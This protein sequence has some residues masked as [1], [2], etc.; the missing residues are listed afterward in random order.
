MRRLALFFFLILSF[1]RAISQDSV[2]LAHT[3]DP[4]AALEYG[5]GVDRLG[6]AKMSFLDSGVTLTVVDSFRDE[7]KIRLSQL[8]TAYIG[9]DH[10][11]LTRKVA[12]RETG[13]N[14]HLSGDWKIYGDDR[15]DFVEIAL[16]SR[17]PYHS[18]QQINPSRIIVE[19]YG[20]TSNTNWINQ[21]RSAREIRACWYEQTEDDLLRVIVELRHPTFWGHSLYY[22]S[23]GRK[24][25]LRVRRQPPSL[26]IRKL[27]IA[28]DAGHGGGNRGSSGIVTGVL[29]KDY[30]LLFAKDLQSQLRTAGVRQVGMT[31]TKDTSL[32]MPERI[33]ILKAFD[34][35]FL[36]SLH[37]NASDQDT[38]RGVST[39]YRYIGFRP[40]SQ[41]LLNQLLSLGLH[42]FGNVGS[43]NFAL[44][45][46][47]D[48]PNALVEI[49]FLSNAQDEKRIL[50]PKFRRAVAQKIYQGILGWLKEV[51]Q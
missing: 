19:L 27:R 40:L 9:K 18:Y 51:R 3:G 50:N 36:I 46:P 17:L 4:L 49:A 29:E 13:N 41:A 7:Y 38:V 20:V 6:G 24:L 25:I 33:S 47:T 31:R 30:T 15:A 14:E 32:S 34:P 35:D 8:H 37:L 48:Y 26:D 16:D 28:I 42:E 12:D 39:Y 21:L 23:S 2:Y 44:N 43:F 5:I 1:S 11:V 45:G 22:D 10:V